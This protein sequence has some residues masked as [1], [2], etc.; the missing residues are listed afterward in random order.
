MDRVKLGVGHPT[1]ASLGV[2]RVLSPGGKALQFTEVMVPASKKRKIAVLTPDNAAV[3]LRNSFD[4]TT[5]TE[6]FAAMRNTDLNSET[7]LTLL[8]QCVVDQSV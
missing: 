1:S 3:V 6:S 2:K 8:T 4:L 7:L 5:F